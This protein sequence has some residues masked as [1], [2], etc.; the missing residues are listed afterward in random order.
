M[1]NLENIGTPIAI[2]KNEGKKTKQSP[3]ISI[4]DSETAR[5]NYNEIKLKAVEK[6]QQVPNPNTERSILYITGRSGSGKSYYTL[7][8]CMEYKKMYPKRNIYLFSALESD[9]TL[10][11]LKGLQR[12]K[13]SEEFCEEDIVAEDFKDC[14]VIFD[15]S[16]VI[17]SKPIKN[18]VNHIMNQ[19]LQTG[20]HFNT[21]CIITTHSACSGNATK[22][23]L[24][25]AH[26]IT[27]FPSG[28]GNR[29]MKYL[30]DS[31][32]GLDKNQIKKIKNL[33]S[34]WVTIFRTFPLAI[35]SERDVYTL[36]NNDD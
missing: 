3:I 2:I 34:R 27:I 32:F 35:L 25:E 15:D 17:S 28:L 5:T 9:S 18:K 13:L 14:L 31:Y 10:D 29:S 7:N 4:D 33:K 24:G 21:S 20:R 12:F 19:I 1:I 23:I 36:N 11:K 22:I 30:L 6:F 8:Y 16:D 26:S